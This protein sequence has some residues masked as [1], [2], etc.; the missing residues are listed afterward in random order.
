MIQPAKQGKYREFLRFW[1]SRR[2]LAAKNTL[3]S[4]VYLIEIP[5]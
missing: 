5:Y 4:L 2:L 1:P 3:S